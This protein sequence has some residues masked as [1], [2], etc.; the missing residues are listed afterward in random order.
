MGYWQWLRSV[1]T[2]TVVQEHTRAHQHA[3][4]QL[5]DEMVPTEV[6]CT[7]HAAQHAHASAS[8]DNCTHTLPSTRRR[9]AVHVRPS[10]KKS[11]RISVWTTPLSSPRRSN[12]AC[13]TATIHRSS[14]SIAHHAIKTRV[15]RTARYSA[16][17]SISVQSWQCSHSIHGALQ[18]EQTLGIRTLKTQCVYAPST[19]TDTFHSRAQLTAINRCHRVDWLRRNS[20]SPLLVTLPLQ[21]QL[22][23]PFRSVHATTI[24]PT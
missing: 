20:R 5:H 6:N 18:T 13:V 12:Q 8:A 9:A 2:Y 11:V 3:L 4:S 23:R 14:I 15:T 17:Q 22:K 1:Q 16:S 24:A 10:P 21:R 7:I 19:H